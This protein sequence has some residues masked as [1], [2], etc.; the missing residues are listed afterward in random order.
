[1]PVRTGGGHGRTIDKPAQGEGRAGCDG[2]GAAHRSE[3]G[4]TGPR[5]PRLPT[6]VES[7]S[8]RPTGGFMVASPAPRRNAKAA[9]DGMREKGA[10]QPLARRAGREPDGMAPTPTSTATVQGALGSC[11]CHAATLGAKFAERVLEL[12]SIGWQLF[13]LDSSQRDPIAFSAFLDTYATRLLTEP[14][15]RSWLMRAAIPTL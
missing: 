11:I 6:L 9:P 8:V 4:G 1:M 13:I 5:T 12:P 2:K 14:L 7:A 10:A 15:S 3:A